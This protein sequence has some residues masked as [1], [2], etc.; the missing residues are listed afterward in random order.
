MP[1]LRS[2]F[3]AFL[4]WFA[5]LLVLPVCY[6]YGIE[7]FVVHPVEASVALSAYRLCFGLISSFFV[8][9]WQAKVGVGWVF[10]M[11]AFFSLFV[12]LIMLGVVWKGHVVWRWN[13][14]REIAV[15]E[16]GA[17]ISVRAEE[18]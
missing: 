11:S 7:C 2:A 1:R 3:G 8:L 16:D 15:T 17:R 4:I 6:N 18:S 13:I 10:G 12:A 9:D 5:A 14:S